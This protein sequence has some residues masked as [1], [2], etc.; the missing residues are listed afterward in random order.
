MIS[1]LHSLRFQVRHRLV[2]NLCFSMVPQLRLCTNTRRLHAQVGS[3]VFNGLLRL[4][5]R[6]LVV[7]RADFVHQRV[8]VVFDQAL[9]KV[10]H[11]SECGR[12]AM[13]IDRPKLDGHSSGARGLLQGRSCYS[14]RR[15]KAHKVALEA[16]VRVALLVNLPN[17]RTN[18]RTNGFAVELTKLSLSVAATVGS[19]RH[20]TQHMNG[21]AR[22]P[23]LRS[24]GMQPQAPAAPVLG[25]ARRGEA[26]RGEA[27]TSTCISASKSSLSLPDLRIKA[28]KSVYILSA[29]SEAQPIPTN[30]V[31][32]DRR[33]AV[34]RASLALQTGAG[35][36]ELAAMS[37]SAAP[38]CVR[39]RGVPLVT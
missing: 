36:W 3:P 2:N 9:A 10:D 20:T 31:R 5:R 21:R 28:M 1:K 14:Q 35:G 18:K 33:V 19:V 32:L 8:L 13:H 25:E 11:P 29:R 22:L 24:N 27:R 39:V 30:H 15:Q 37:S 26:R 4:A 6:R 17:E 7:E 16:S 12:N 34:P 38:I 23:V